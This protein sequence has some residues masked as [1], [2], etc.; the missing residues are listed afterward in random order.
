MA[1]VRI[2]AVRLCR[3]WLQGLTV[4][5]VPPL[6]LSAAFVVV[7][8]VLNAHAPGLGWPAAVVVAVCGWAL[9]AGTLVLAVLTGWGRRH[10]A[11]SIGFGLAGGVCL[12]IWSRPPTAAVVAVAASFVPVAAY[13]AFVLPVLIAYVAALR[14]ARMV[15]PRARIVLDL[16]TSA[17]LT[18]AN[19]AWVRRADARDQLAAVLERVARTA[20]RDLPRLLSRRGADR[21]TKEWLANRGRVVAAGVRELK[22]RMLFSRVSRVED[23]RGE[24]ARLLLLACLGDW[25]EIGGD[26]TVPRARGFLRTFLGNLGVSAAL[27]AGAA[28][29]HWV[30]APA[31]GGGLMNFRDALIAA[32][33][34]ALIPLPRDE[35][36]RISDTF[37]ELARP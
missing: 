10:L 2:S 23:L 29:I 17:E 33:V 1:A 30:V 13:A 21:A 25:S 26:R 11:L 5:L 34:L 8:A 20:E 24:L 37:G 35:L 12:V 9:A 28:L 22:Q 31:A 18:T 3:D 7:L 32:G 14:L 16:L 4:W 15:D 36:R 27:F 19:T 6:S